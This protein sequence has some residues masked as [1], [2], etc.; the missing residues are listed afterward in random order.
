MNKYHIEI[1]L[2]SDTTFG[3]GDG[4]AGYIDAEVEHDEFGLPFLRGRT[5]KGLL[6]EECANILFALQTDAKFSDFE[7]A[8]DNLFGKAGSDLEA[9]A[10]MFVGDAVIQEDLRNAIKYAIDKNQTTADEILQSLTTI[11]RQTAMSEKGSPKAESLRSIR[12]ILRETIFESNLSFDKDYPIDSDEIVLLG[13]TCKAL[14]RVGLARNRGR[15]K[16]SVKLFGANN[17]TDVCVRKFEET[18]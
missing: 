7:K 5:L 10:K 1:T 15:G 13:M 8:A 11:R 9:D 18:V 4:V 12:V 17:L 3:R 6:Q 2:K 16:V 14:Q